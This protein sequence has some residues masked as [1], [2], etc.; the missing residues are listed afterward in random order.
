MF[1]LAAALGVSAAFAASGVEQVRTCFRAL[2]TENLSSA[3][4][5]EL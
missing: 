2:R 4:R 1:K 5:H 3:A